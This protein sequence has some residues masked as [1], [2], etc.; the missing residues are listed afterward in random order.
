[1]ATIVAGEPVVALNKEYV[2]PLF[3]I[4]LILVHV[5]PWSVD[6]CARVP[7]TIIFPLSAAMMLL[8]LLPSIPLSISFQPAPPL[9]VFQTPTSLVPAYSVFASFAAKQ[10]P[11]SPTE[12][13]NV[14]LT[15]VQVP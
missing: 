11:L 12:L 15:G 8:K 10:I 6:I 1:M 7:A 14:V 9:I 3:T 13:T 5:A 4:V 2:G